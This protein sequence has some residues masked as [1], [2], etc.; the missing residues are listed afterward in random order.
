MAEKPEAASL[1]PYLDTRREWNERYGSYLARAHHWR[2]AALG[3]LL[4]SAILAAG[5]VALAVGAAGAPA[6]ASPS[7]TTGGATVSDRHPGHPLQGLRRAESAGQL[8][9]A[10]NGDVVRAGQDRAGDARGRDHDLL[11]GQAGVLR[12]AQ[13]GNRRQRQQDQHRSF[14]HD[15]TSRVEVQSV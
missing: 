9:P 4:V 2:L 1:P 7:A 3:S 8:L 15:G 13:G 11:H 10:H 5:L 12:G 14:G 6:S